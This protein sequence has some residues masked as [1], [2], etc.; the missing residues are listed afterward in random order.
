MDELPIVK[1]LRDGSTYLENRTL[2][3]PI[4]GSDLDEAAALIRELEAALDDLG[5]AV[6]EEDDDLIAAALDKTRAALAKAR[7]A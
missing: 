5:Y 7:E 1:R 6:C 2:G 4:T 3:E